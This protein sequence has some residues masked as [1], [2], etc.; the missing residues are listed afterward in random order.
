VLG[1]SCPLTVPVK[2]R[3]RKGVSAA[4]AHG[5]NGGGGGLESVSQ[6]AEALG[7]ISIFGTARASYKQCIEQAICRRRNRV[8]AAQ[9]NITGRNRLCEISTEVARSER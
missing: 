6:G 5:E 9:A 3:G 7:F 8:S 1:T 4:I 2:I